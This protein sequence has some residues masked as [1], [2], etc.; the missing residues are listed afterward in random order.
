MQRSVGKKCCREVMQRSVVETC[1]TR[2]LEEIVGEE[3]CRR[4]LLSTVI[5]KCWGGVW[6]CILFCGLVLSCGL[7]G[8]KE[9]ACS[10]PP[11]SLSMARSAAT[12]IVQADLSKNGASAKYAYIIY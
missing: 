7:V 4:E 12:D 10:S 9:T 6:Y 8:G 2:L 11:E 1:W 3:C 5:E